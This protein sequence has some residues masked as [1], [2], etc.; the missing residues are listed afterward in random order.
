M[1]AANEFAREARQ[2]RLAFED[3]VED[4]RG[5][6]LRAQE[7]QN[8]ADAAPATVELAFEN[9]GEKANEQGLGLV[10][11]HRRPARPSRHQELGDLLE[12]GSPLAR[13]RTD[14]VE[15]VV[16]MRA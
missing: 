12:V 15:R 5:I 13:L 14:E 7:P 1:K 9:I 6:F 10:L 16:A 2:V 11:P 4:N 8:L 3:T